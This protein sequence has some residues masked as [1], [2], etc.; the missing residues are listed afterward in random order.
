MPSSR[1]DKN[2]E[3]LARAMGSYDIANGFA[4]EDPKVTPLRKRGRPRKVVAAAAPAGPKPKG[5]RTPEQELDERLALYQL[6]PLKKAEDLPP[7]DV[8]DVTRYPAVPEWKPH[9]NP[10]VT[11]MWQR[12]SYAMPE[13]S[14]SPSDLKLWREQVLFMSRP[15]LAQMLRVNERTIR[16]WESG[17]S[18]I[19]FPMWWVMSCTL[20]DPEFF[21]DRPGFHDF[22]IE[23]DRSL[24]E[25]VLCSS[26]WPDI[27]CTP[28]DLYFQRAA[29]NKVL[30][31]DAKL[32]AKQKEVDALTAENTRLRQ[33]LKAGTVASELAAMHAHIGN[34]LE[35][36][37]TA[38][39]VSFPGPDG[40]PEVAD[41]PRQASA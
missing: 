15:Q 2:P 19:P 5:K 29:G 39:I 25:P 40:L 30:Q 8:T 35:R 36:M 3:N 27:R 23:Y 21:L 26:K 34:L 31:L 18:S 4:N 10:N 20:Q 38:D 16:M 24:G 17:K 41:F 12:H 22:Y 11:R 7:Y 32:A 37:H 6:E 14:I 28:S 1:F 13:R 9:A 33:M